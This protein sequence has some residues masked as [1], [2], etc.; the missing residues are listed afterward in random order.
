MEKLK[1]T[2]VKRVDQDLRVREELGHGSTFLISNT[3]IIFSNTPHFLFNAV[4]RDYWLS[5]KDLLIF[6]CLIIEATLSAFVI[7]QRW[8]GEK[9]CR[10]WHIKKKIIN[11]LMKFTSTGTT[12]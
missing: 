7:L 5:L 9:P 6:K 1:S 12:F 11:L 4:K 2:E 8:Q 3:T 10:Q